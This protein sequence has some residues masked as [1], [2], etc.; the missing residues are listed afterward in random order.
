MDRQLSAVPRGVRWAL[1]VALVVQL[2]FAAL[3]PPP[4][5][6]AEAL[7]VLPSAQ[8]LRIA[9]LGEP[10]ALAQMLTLYLQAFDNQS[11]VSIPFLQ[12]DYARVESWLERILE[13][14][15]VGQYPL[16]LAAQ[17]YAQVPDEHK[18]RQ[19]LELVYR[20][21]LADPNRRWP[22]LGHAAI[23]ARHRLNDQPLALRYAQALRTHATAASVPAWARQME[24]FLREDMGEY[25]AAKVLLGGLL[26]S[27]TVTDSHELA[28]LVE[29]LKALEAAEKSSRAS[30]K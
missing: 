28:F 2:A 11:G 4:S 30:K 10:I 29:R 5:G 6:N 19:M 23:M 16:L 3:Q 15:P 20:N 9:S 1:G 17:V 27:G 25:E 26:A 21:F 18:Q 8:V 24:I 22:W 13:L 12:L 14:D 7:P